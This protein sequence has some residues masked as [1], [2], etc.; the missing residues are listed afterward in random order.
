MIKNLKIWLKSK[1]VPFSFTW[2]FTWPCL[3]KLLWAFDRINT[4]LISFI[5]FFLSMLYMQGQVCAMN[6]NVLFHEV[7]IKEHIENILKVPMLRQIG[8]WEFQL[9]GARGVSCWIF[10]RWWENFLRY[11]VKPSNIVLWNNIAKKSVGIVKVPMES[12]EKHLK[13]D[14]FLIFLIFLI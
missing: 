3:V 7:E 2:N 12:R 13:S 5:F 1:F 8:V 6:V 11:M 14:V 10:R 4:S 9:L